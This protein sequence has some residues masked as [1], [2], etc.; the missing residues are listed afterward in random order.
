V[1]G[2]WQGFSGIYRSNAF[3]PDVEK[4]I[5]REVKGFVPRTLLVSREM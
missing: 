2:R 1:T 5:A 3:L 4:L